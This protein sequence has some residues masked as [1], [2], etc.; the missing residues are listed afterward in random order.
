MRRDDEQT[1]GLIGFLNNEETEVTVK[2]ERA[3]LKELEG[4]CQVPIAA[5]CQAKGKVLHLEGMVAELDGSH[6]I[7]DEIRGEKSQAEEMGISLARR[8]LASGA[9][10]ILERIYGEK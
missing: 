8:L 4:G 9:D 6:V 3:F 7:R 2:A 5:F 1:I 10:K